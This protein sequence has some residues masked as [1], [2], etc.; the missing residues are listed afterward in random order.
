ML[1]VPHSISIRFP[2]LLAVLLA[3]L[4]GAGLYWIDRQGQ[5]LIDQDEVE[6]AATTSDTVISSLKSIMLA[7]P[8]RS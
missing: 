7:G 3:V 2:L 1:S 5:T 8:R 4:L 6:R